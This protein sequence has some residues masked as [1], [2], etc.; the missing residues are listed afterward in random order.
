MTTGGP[1]M[2]P[3]TPIEQVIPNVSGNN[4]ADNNGSRKNAMGQ[5]VANSAFA[6]YKQQQPAT[7]NRAVP[8]P[9]E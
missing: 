6:C 7:S 5:G 4:T 8:F 9:S 2:A 1:L 3:R